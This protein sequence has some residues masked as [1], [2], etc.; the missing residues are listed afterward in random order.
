MENIKKNRIDWIDLTKGLAILLVIIGH[1]TLI[2]TPES[3]VRGIIF[4]VHM[5]LFFM[6][7]SITFQYSS[8]FEQFLLKIKKSA[9]H[10]LIPIL[11]V[12]CFLIV[13]EVITSPDTSLNLSYFKLKIYT[14][15]FTSGVDIMYADMIIPA[16]GIPWFFMALFIGRT[17]FDYI[18]MTFHPNQLPIICSLVT[19]CGVLC[20]CVLWLPFSLDISFAT[21]LFFF[22]GYK[23]KSYDM[24]KHSFCNSLLRIVFYLILW[25]FT[26]WLTF[27]NPDN[28]TYL[29]FACRRYHTFPVCYMTAFFGTMFFIELSHLLSKAKPLS[30][31]IIY[32]GKNSM[33]LLLVHCL[34]TIFSKYFANYPNQFIQAL[35]RVICN[36][37]IFAIVMLIIELSRFIRNHRTK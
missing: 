32:I 12:W 36:L 1:S 7:S 23:L 30:T 3:I 11:F 26:L 10:L 2:G 25:L 31:P 21:V 9:R 4:S 33:Y 34:D 6:L 24:T 15:F 37:I 18:Q 35:A 8:T 13:Y 19:L 5:P 14:L 20:G 28:W 17:I 27:P 22:A 16:I 29:E